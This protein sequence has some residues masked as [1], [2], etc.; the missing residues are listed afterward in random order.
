MKMRKV[1]LTE[2]YWNNESLV[3]LFKPL[4]KK[5]DIVR[6]AFETV[7]NENNAIGFCGVRVRC[8]A[9]GLPRGGLVE[10]RGGVPRLRPRGQSCKVA[11]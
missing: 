5:A 4:G 1:E 2:R 7:E 8:I 9:H 11:K 10:Q 3:I 6:N